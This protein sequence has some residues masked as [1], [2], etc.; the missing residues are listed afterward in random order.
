MRRIEDYAMIGDCKTA[1]LISSEGCIDWLCLPAFDSEAC[2]AALLGTKENGFWSIRPQEEIR[3][4]SRSYKENTLILD[5]IFETQHGKMR[6]TDFMPPDSDY[7][8]IIRIVEGLEGYVP[9]EME[10]CPRFEYGDLIPLFKK[11]NDHEVTVI[12]GPDQL[13]IR[14]GTKLE[15]NSYKLLSSFQVAKGERVTFQMCWSSSHK[16]KGPEL[17]PQKALRATHDFWEKWLKSCHVDDYSKHPIIIKRAI[18]TLKAMTFSPA[19][20]IVAAVT[21]S[22][23]EVLGGERNWDYRYCWPRDAA[24]AMRAVLNS[25]GQRE[26]VEAWRHWLVR[27]TAGLPSQMEVLY[28]LDGT[29][30][31]I[32]VTLPWLKGYEESVPVRVGNLAHNQLQL[33]IFGS[34]IEVFYMAESM[35]LPHLKEAWDLVRGMLKY[36]EKKWQEPDE[37]IWEVRGPKRNFV[38]SK[39]MVWAAFNWCIKAHENFGI[40]GPVDH[41]KKIRSEIHDDICK[42]GFNKRLNSFTQFYGSEEVDANLLRIPLLG[43]LPPHDPRITGTIKKIEEDLLIEEG[44]IMRYLP[45]EEVE[46]LPPNGKRAFLLCSGWL[47]EVYALLGRC[48]D[49]K[50]VYDKLISLV[51]DVGLLAEQY[52]PET[53]RQLGNFPQ[54]F[55]HIALIR[56][57]LALRKDGRIEES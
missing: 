30:P 41:W 40:E 9:I 14:T 56:L 10:M 39:L 38:H 28:K 7:V 4:T 22:L 31:T 6:I 5:T 35:G 44:L 37:G 43:F 21:T 29:R 34:V 15:I 57:E 3:N 50:K 47:G 11:E 8:D 16:E 32:E 46:G 1:A 45:N 33:D 54:A 19:G 24:L 48:E 25:T 18:L 42:N 36:L 12:R 52:D 26:E 17:E 23:P 27:A 2:F 55:S 13:T 53:G 20:S 49:A 51:N